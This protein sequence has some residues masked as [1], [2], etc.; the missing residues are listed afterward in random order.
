MA[1]DRQPFSAFGSAPF[2]YIASLCCGHP[3]AET[4]GPGM[5]NPAG[6]ERSFHDTPPFLLKNKFSMKLKNTAKNRVRLCPAD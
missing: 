3:F 4:V 6:L 2:D 5:L 1:S